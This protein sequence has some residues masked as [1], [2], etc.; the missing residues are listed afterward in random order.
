MFKVPFKYYPSIV[1]D[2]KAYPWPIP[3]NKYA[4]DRKMLNEDVAF[5]TV[6][7][8]QEAVAKAVN[9]ASQ[10]DAV[11][12]LRIDD[13]YESKG[14][15]RTQLYQKQISLGQVPMIRPFNQINYGTD[16]RGF[17]GIPLKQSSL[18]RYARSGRLFRGQLITHDRYP[19]KIYKVGAFTKHYDLNTIDQLNP[20]ELERVHQ[21]TMVEYP[22]M[23]KVASANKTTIT[24][25]PGRMREHRAKQVLTNALR[26]RV[27]RNK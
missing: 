19:R 7:R 14:V 4:V 10:Y 6:V 17:V 11:S 8:K 13:I 22:A 2:P 24:G 18:D 20:D 21:S 5:A 12:K 15:E 9:A 23:L 25:L 26:K 1:T 3:Q 27:E 16:I